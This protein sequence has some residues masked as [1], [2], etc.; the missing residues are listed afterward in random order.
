MADLKSPQLIVAKGLMFLAIAA[1]SA[2]LILS[3]LPSL[4]VAVLL[5][6][7]VWAACRFYYFLFYVLERYVDPSLRYSGLSA[8]LAEWFRRRARRSR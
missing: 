5:G 1:M 4:R 2:Y 3:E 7:L 6:L 8:L